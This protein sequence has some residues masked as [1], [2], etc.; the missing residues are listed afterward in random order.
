MT[1]TFALFI[2]IVLYIIFSPSLKQHDEYKNLK[3]IFNELYV[4]EEKI[5]SMDI[6]SII[7]I[8]ELM[9]TDYLKLYDTLSSKFR[10]YLNTADIV[11][12]GALA[13]LSTTRM[14][15]D[16]AILFHKYNTCI[17]ELT[18]RGIDLTFNKQKFEKYEENLSRMIKQLKDDSK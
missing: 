10:D 8:V 9:E 3:N 13:E 2:I 1:L 17:D 5:K 18:N 11:Y 4:Y 14:N 6:E 15:Y 7:K 16:N 12:I